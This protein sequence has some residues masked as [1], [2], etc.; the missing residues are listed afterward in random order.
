MGNWL[1]L[2]SWVMKKVGDCFCHPRLFAFWPPAALQCRSK[3]SEF[4]KTA[5][6]MIWRIGLLILA[7]VLGLLE[8][9]QN[10]L[11]MNPNSR[12]W[13]KRH[14]FWNWPFGRQRLLNADPTKWR[15]KPTTRWMY[16]TSDWLLHQL[17][18]WSCDGK[19][20]ALSPTSKISRALPLSIN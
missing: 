1:H 17:W 9:T 6:Q 14:Q 3:Q 4:C 18:S 10:L 5:C 12:N 11:I 15:E 8:Y 7:I 2:H 19:H 20:L 16:Q 13:R